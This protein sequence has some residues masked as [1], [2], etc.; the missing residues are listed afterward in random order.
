MPTP[1]RQRG[2]AITVPRPRLMR[3]LAGRWKIAVLSAP[4]GYGKS[5]LAT[6]YASG[7]NALFSRIHP[8]DRD[9]AH[10]L[11]TLLASGVRLRPPV[12]IRTNRL[13]AARRDMERDGGLLTGSFID[14]LSRSR[15]ERLV[16]LDDVH[17]L[18]EARDAA[19]WISQVIEESGP[20]VRFLLTCRGDCP[21]PLARFDLQGGSVLLRTDDLEFTDSEQ[22]SL[23][24]SRLGVRLSEEETMRLRD[25]VGGWAAGLVLAS[26]RFQQTGRVPVPP[27]HDEDGER[28]ERLVSFLAD[29]VFAPLPPRLKR[30]LCRAAIL[31]ELDRDSVD[32]LMGPVEGSY[33][34][35][36]IV[37]RDLF[38]R[39]LPDGS[40]APRFHPLFRAYLLSQLDA[41][42]SRSE[43]TRLTGR[44]AKYWLRRGEPDRAIRALVDAKDFTPARRLF[45]EAARKH[46]RAA[47]NASLGPL[48]TVI[49]GATGI[50]SPWVSLHAAYDARA[51][52]DYDEVARLVHDAQ[53][54]FCRRRAFTLC[55]R[56]FRVE[57]VTAISSG[58]IRA[59]VDR[60]QSLLT[61]LPARE[62]LARGIVAVQMGN[63]LLH[64]GRPADAL[65]AIHG[66]IRGIEAAGDRFEL[67][68]GFV[69]L[70]NVH[71]TRGRWDLYIRLARGAIDAYRRSGYG[72]PLGSLLINTA[73]AHIYL[74]EEEKAIACFDEARELR[75]RTGI[76]LH[77]VDEA[78]GRARAYSEMG[79]LAEALPLFEAARTM[80]QR[81]AT[82]SASL[83]LDVWEGVFERRRG[84]MREALTHLGHAV[85]GYSRLEMPSWLAL[86]RIERALALGLSGRV[87]EG[88]AELAE[89]TPVSRRLGDKKELA[90]VALYEARIL[91][92][93]RRDFEPHLGRALRMLE[94]EHYL[95]LLRKEPD[96]SITLF[97]KASGTPLVRRALAALPESLRARVPGRAAPPAG[98]RGRHATI[99][100]LGRFDVAVDSTPVIFPRRASQVLVSYLALHGR[101]VAREAIAE[102]IWPEARAAASRNRFDVT[103]S[104]ARRALEP[105]VGLRGPF[106]I[107][108]TEA[109]MCRLNRD[110]VDVDVEAF[111]EAA[112]RC[113]PVFEI[114]SL[115]PWAARLPLSAPE[116]RHA[117]HKIQHAI[118]LYGGD[119]LPDL[120]YASWVLAERDRLRERY[121]R[122]LIARGVIALVLGRADEAAEAAQQILTADPL[123]EEAL[124]LT[125]RALAALGEKGAILRVYRVFSRR[126]ERQLDSSPGP[127]TAALFRELTG[128]ERSNRI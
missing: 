84:R 111:E 28:S 10:L 36:E 95:V 18:G 57:A 126:M 88:L 9:T 87:D 100:L 86:A 23:L 89:V 69:Q 8:E 6:Q 73:E 46:P 61:R 115:R 127:E 71:F 98:R 48:A 43:R 109:G 72:L 75:A 4:A 37:R 110:R 31:E 83:S 38:I 97:S 13:F 34:L 92:A 78:I 50:A 56:A 25:A 107:L 101:S 19:N 80:A 79:A 63:L 117:R 124:R 58:R 60:G 30:D 93:A 114:L 62:T 33:L 32:T 45:E 116:A 5:T 99:R 53:E 7:H 42:G 85:D 125:M 26:H 121:Q 12:G 128:Q 3:L 21:I 2:D 54:G 94:R 113:Q 65:T 52:G 59:V 105:E 91:Q 66:G 120:P 44:L 102:A 39:T 29:E 118:G 64:A 74:G 51:R 40:G 90:R 106:R 15:G 24:R 108:L 70:A 77:A 49:E 76:R 1:A 47:R 14:E 82:P 103:L 96:L 67:A 81:W 122:L 55:A 68:E 20:R 22:R 11:G 123:H 27:R 119:L 112:G 35:R 16:V 41:Q 17:L 104:A